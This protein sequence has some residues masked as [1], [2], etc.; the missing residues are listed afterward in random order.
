MDKQQLGPRELCVEAGALDAGGRFAFWLRT[1]QDFIDSLRKLR[2]DGDS[3][4]NKKQII[5]N[6]LSASVN[7]CAEDAADYAV[8]VMCST[9]GKG[10]Q[11]PGRRI[12][13]AGAEKSE[14]CHKYFLQY[15]AVQLFSK[16]LFPTW[17]RQTYFLLRAPSNLVTPMGVVRILQSLRQQKNN[18]CARYLLVSRRKLQ[19]ETMCEYLQ[20]LKTLARI[21]R[22]L[23]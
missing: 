14:Q 19:G 11:F 9:R 22:F 3:E 8:V 2:R 13:A 12:T 15:S 10:A 16:D 18:A 20:V 17:G 6:C 23:L 5:I 1:V 7:L 21:A 4:V